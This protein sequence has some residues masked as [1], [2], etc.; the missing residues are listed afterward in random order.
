VSEHSWTGL[1]CIGGFRLVANTWQLDPR[2]RRE[3]PVLHITFTR[4]A[5]PGSAGQS[6]A[7]CG[8]KEGRSTDVAS[9]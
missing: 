9:R 7:S 3:Q 1:K 5:P 8:E 4:K 6:A 2:P